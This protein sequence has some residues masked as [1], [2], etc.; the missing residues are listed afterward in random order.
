MRR[1]VAGIAGSK[2]TGSR[3]LGSALAAG[4]RLVD[5]GHGVLERTAGSEMLSAAN[6][7]LDL[8]V[9][10][11]ILDAALLAAGLLLLLGLGLPVDARS[12]HDVLADGGGVERGTGSVALLQAELVPGAS[13][14]DPGVHMLADDGG[15]DAAGHLDLLVVIVEAVRDHGLGS[16]FVRRHLLRGESG[17][18]IELL[19]VGPVGAAGKRKNFWLEEEGDGRALLLRTGLHLLC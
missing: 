6:T 11:L 12:E 3:L 7:A 2:T 10:E 5:R 14:G 4:A 13:L 18:V 9:L 16:I 15:F 1:H 19:V 17:G 8:L